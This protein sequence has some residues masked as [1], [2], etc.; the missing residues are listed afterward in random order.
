MERRREKRLS[1]VGMIE[2]FNFHSSQHNVVIN[3]PVEI[4]LIDMSAGGL[5]IKSNVALE[6]DT[7]ISINIQFDE[8][9]Y[10]VIGRVVWCT[11]E[12][13]LYNCGL[14]LIYIPSELRDHLEDKEDQQTKYIN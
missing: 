8:T 12:G 13:N 9:N 11:Q 5:G 3:T 7:T 10:V 2:S 14:K 6:N 4:S 1:Q